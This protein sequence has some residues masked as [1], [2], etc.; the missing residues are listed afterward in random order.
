M[1]QYINAFENYEV[2]NLGNVR[3]LLKSGIYINIECSISNRGYKYFQ[4]NRNKKRINF[5][6]HYLVIEKFKGD[7][8]E[9]L[10]IDHIDRNKLNNHIDNLR[11]VTQY[12]NVKNCDR[13]RIDILEEDPKKRAIIRAKEYVDNNREHVLQNKRE[14]YQ[15]NKEHMKLLASI[16]ITCTCGKEMNKASLRRHLKTKEHNAMVE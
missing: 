11:Y 10:V 6:V 1:E 2:S 15:K 13:Y 14:Y 3:R 9:K 16:K 12:E 8:P 5:Y 7:R 4:L